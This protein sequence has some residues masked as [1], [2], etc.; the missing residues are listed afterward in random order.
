MHPSTSTVGYSVVVAV[1]SF[2]GLV[3]VGTTG[4]L[5]HNDLINLQQGKADVDG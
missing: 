5:A 3:H 1:G 2:G 4:G